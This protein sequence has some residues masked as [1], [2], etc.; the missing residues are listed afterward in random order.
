MRCRKRE[1]QRQGQAKRGE[2]KGRFLGKIN[3][4]RKEGLIKAQNM[5]KDGRERDHIY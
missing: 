5:Q 3:Y 4:T 1:K 2:K